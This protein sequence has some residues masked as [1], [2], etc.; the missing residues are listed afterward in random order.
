MKILRLGEV[1]SLVQRLIKI[2]ELELKSIVFGFI[3]FG[4]NPNTML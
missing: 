1:K 3:V 2:N 4:M